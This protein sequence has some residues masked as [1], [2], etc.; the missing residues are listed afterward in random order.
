MDA[1][2]IKGLAQSPVRANISSEVL[3]NSAIFY[4]DATEAN[5]GCVHVKKSVPKTSGLN[6]WLVK[7]NHWLEKN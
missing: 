2:Y 3:D 1:P 6:R 7:I 5:I 4:R